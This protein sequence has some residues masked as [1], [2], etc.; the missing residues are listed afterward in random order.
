MFIETDTQGPSPIW[1]LLGD[2][3]LHGVGDSMHRQVGDLPCTRE[4]HGADLLLLL[5]LLILIWPSTESE[6]PRTGRS[7]TET[8]H[9]PRKNEVGASV[10]KLANLVPQ[11]SVISVISC[12]KP[13]YQ[14]I[15]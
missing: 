15:N 8:C 13:S 4:Q 7:E 14:R 6:T 9:T 12:S 2:M 3:A 11:F 10:D 1:R 5:L